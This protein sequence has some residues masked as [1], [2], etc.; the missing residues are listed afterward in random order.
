MAKSGESVAAELLCDLV[1]LLPEEAPR[2]GLRRA[3]LELQAEAA[4]LAAPRAKA[5]AAPKAVP[6][7][8]QVIPRCD[9][10]W[11][12]K[13]V[14]QLDEKLEKLALSRSTRGRR[15]THEGRRGLTCL[16]PLLGG[17]LSFLASLGA[18]LETMLQHSEAAPVA[19][20]AL[21]RNVKLLDPQQA[22]L[23]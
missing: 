7:A 2:H 20:Q 11:K 4:A 21:K 22:G 15:S 5:R 19:L 18:V 16:D 13:L 12:R 23:G 3:L 6:K 1:L 17:R 9:S 8:M 14:R 10:F